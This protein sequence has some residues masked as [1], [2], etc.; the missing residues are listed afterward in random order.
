MLHAISLLFHH[1]HFRLCY[2][3]LSIQAVTRETGEAYAAQVGAIFIE[4]SARDNVNVEELFQHIS[5]SFSRSYVS[6]TFMSP[7]K[8]ESRKLRMRIMCVTHHASSTC[9]ISS[10]TYHVGICEMC[11][12]LDARSDL[13]TAFTD[14]VMNR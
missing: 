11:F 8:D 13:I 2:L 6:D 5:K 1:G 3:L 10:F 4:T 14:F 12:C 7:V 9:V